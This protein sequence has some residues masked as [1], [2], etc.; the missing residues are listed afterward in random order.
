MK[1]FHQKTVE[2]K[3]LTCGGRGLLED[4]VENL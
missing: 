1:G 4:S 2:W 3:L